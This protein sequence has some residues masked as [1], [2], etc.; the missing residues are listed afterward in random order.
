[1]HAEPRYLFLH[2]HYPVHF[3][4]GEHNLTTFTASVAHIFGRAFDAKVTQFRTF[5]SCAE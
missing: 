5:I 4:P 2:E 3:R 1:M